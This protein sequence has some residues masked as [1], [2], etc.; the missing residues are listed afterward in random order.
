M[1][2]VV[3]AIFY[4]VRIGCQWENLPKE[5]PNHNSV[6]EGTTRW[7]RLPKG[8]HPAQCRV[9]SQLRMLARLWVP[10]IEALSGK[11]S[12]CPSCDDDRI[13]AKDF[14]N[15]HVIHGRATY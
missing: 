1:R 15:P 9:F 3:N 13:A 12:V 2:Q 7:R 14:T 8:K 11:P 4:V 6:Y 5:Y 10:H